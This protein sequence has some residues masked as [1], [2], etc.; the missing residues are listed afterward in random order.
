MGEKTL[1]DVLDAQHSEECWKWHHECAVARIEELTLR[2]EDHGLQ[3]LADDMAGDAAVDA[4]LSRPH[5]VCAEGEET[6]EFWEEKPFA[7]IEWLHEDG[8]DTVGLAEVSGFMLAEDQAG[9]VVG[10]MLDRWSERG[11]E[12][13]MGEVVVST[14]EEGRALCV[15]RQDKEGR[16][17]STIWE[18]GGAATVG[19]DRTVEAP[20][21]RGFGDTFARAVEAQRATTERAKQR[22]TCGNP[23]CEVC[24]AIDNARKPATVEERLVSLAAAVAADITGVSERLSA[25]ESDGYGPEDPAA[26]P[27][28]VE[29]L[30]RAEQQLY[31]LVSRVNRIEDP[32]RG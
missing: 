5:E 4:F 10:D 11:P 25:L 28:L 2:L 27:T 14:D 15:T 32:T 23:D 26:A 30:V 19:F 22:P 29:R 20:R 3:R 16:V 18:A 6:P 21:H 17:L 24:R 8:D 9:T 13:R 12:Q 1:R 31:E 7:R